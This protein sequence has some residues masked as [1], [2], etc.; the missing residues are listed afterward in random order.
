MKTISSIFIIA[1]FTSISSASLVKGYVN[2]KGKYVNAHF[3]RDLK[4]SPYHLRKL[5]IKEWQR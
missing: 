5:K 4:K 1:L 3:R 2:K